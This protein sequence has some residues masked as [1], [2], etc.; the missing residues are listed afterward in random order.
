MRPP[1]HAARFALAVLLVLAALL[2]AGT[3]GATAG[4]TEPRPVSAAA[5]PGGETHETA[6][7]QTAA[8]VRRAHRRP[9]PPPRSARPAVP[10]SAP[11]PAPRPVPTASGTAPRSA[12]MRC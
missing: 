4:E 1:G 10:E 3:G 12:V 9:A 11:A 2:G 6:A 8:P 5:D 7:P